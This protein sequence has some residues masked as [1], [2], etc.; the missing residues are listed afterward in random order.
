MKAA[1][2]VWVGL[3]LEGSVMALLLV[4]TGSGGFGHEAC[5]GL[6]HDPLLLVVELLP[7]ARLGKGKVLE[8]FQM[9]LRHGSPGLRRIRPTRQFGRG[10]HRRWS[11][12]EA[13]LRVSP[14][15]GD[16]PLDAQWSRSRSM[17]PESGIYSRPVG[18][19]RNTNVLVAGSV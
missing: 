6:D 4:I 7:Q 19:E 11:G 12:G 2:W 15:V 8:E 16:R 17:P 3:I 9:Q 14:R 5:E 18:S 1:R 13:S 10:E